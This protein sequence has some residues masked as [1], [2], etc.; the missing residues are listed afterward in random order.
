MPLERY[1]K[2]LQLLWRTP[3][4]IQTK[5]G[6][7]WWRKSD[8]KSRTLLVRGPIISI[9]RLNGCGPF[10]SADKGF[11]SVDW[12]AT[13]LVSPWINSFGPRTSQSWANFATDFDSCELPSLSLLILE[14]RRLIGHFAFLILSIIIARNLRKKKKEEN[15]FY[16]TI[17][18]QSWTRV[19]SSQLGV[20]LVDQIGGVF[21]GVLIQDLRFNFL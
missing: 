15:P 6:S 17:L 1:F 8:Q 20:M 16:T 3:E 5:N 2:T 4:R 7:K 10:R 18:S 19:H 13:D 14:P 9:R 12:M 21:F 11:W